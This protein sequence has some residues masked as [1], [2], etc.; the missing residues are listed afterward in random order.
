M[1]I[2]QSYSSRC[3]HFR[4]QFTNKMNVIYTYPFRMENTLMAILDPVS[5]QLPKGASLAFIGFVMDSIPPSRIKKILKLYCTHLVI[6]M[7][8][9]LLHNHTGLRPI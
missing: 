5:M 9:A 3:D 1:K 7:Y 2:Y 4:E 6:Y 8:V